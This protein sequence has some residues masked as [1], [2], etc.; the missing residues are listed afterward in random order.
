MHPDVKPSAN[1]EACV[2]L[3]FCDESMSLA[4]VPKPRRILTILFLCCA[5]RYL[6]FLNSEFPLGSLRCC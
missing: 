1:V 3:P 2:K 6:G 4:G 5:V